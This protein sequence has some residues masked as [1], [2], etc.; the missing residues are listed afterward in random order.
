[1]NVTNLQIAIVAHLQ[2]KAKLSDFFM[3]LKS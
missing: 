1:M 3:E 2:W